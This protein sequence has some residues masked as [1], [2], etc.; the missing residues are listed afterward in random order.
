MERRLRAIMSCVDGEYGSKTSPGMRI[1]R[2]DA[3]IFN[4]LF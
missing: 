3:H 4:E 1:E 2:G